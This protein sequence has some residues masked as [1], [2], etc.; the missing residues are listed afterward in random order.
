[1]KKDG[2]CRPFFLPGL[3]TRIAMHQ[4]PS[5]PNL[6]SRRRSCR[7]SAWLASLAGLMLSCPAQSQ[8]IMPTQSRDPAQTVYRC[9]QAYTNT[10]PDGALCERLPAQTVTVIPGTRV[11]RPPVPVA[12]ADPVTP[13]SRAT[14]TKPDRTD[15]AREGA[16]GM[17]QT[18]RDAQARSVL[19]AELEHTRERQKALEE[20]RR[21]LHTATSVTDTTRLQSLEQALARTRRDL[22][23]L[24]RELGRK[25]LAGAPR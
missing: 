2:A 11:Q 17:A 13:A 10:P 12:D 16:D 9:G 22:I 23:S 7:V 14:G 25:P 18:Q 21:Q 15:A 5:L 20:E 8:G 19:L 1:M 24:Q 4:P 6:L 3:Y